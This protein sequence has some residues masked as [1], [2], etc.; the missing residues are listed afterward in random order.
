MSDSTS[1][2]RASSTACAAEAWLWGV[3]TIRHVPRSTWAS[4]AAF[5]IFASGPTNTGSMIFRRAA[6]TAPIRDSRS[7][8]WTTPQ[9]TG[10]QVSQALK[11]SRKESLRRSSMWGG[12][13]SS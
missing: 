13:M 3:D 9:V 7:Q 5:R 11:S 6:T 1:P 12:A 8:G 10:A 4:S 2:A